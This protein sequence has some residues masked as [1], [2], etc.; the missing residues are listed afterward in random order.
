MLVGGIDKGFGYNTFFE[1]IAGR[2]NVRAVIVYGR[3]RKE[4]YRAAENA[5]IEEL[6][7]TV[8][9]DSAVR[10]AFGIAKRGDTVLLSPACASFDEFSDFEERGDAFAGLVKSYI[11]ENDLKCEKES[12]ASNAKE[13][14]CEDKEETCSKLKSDGVTQ[15]IKTSI[16]TDAISSFGDDSEIDGE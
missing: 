4:L 11:E 9:F 10:T 8:G 6:Y 12:F 14:R 7:L 3:S 5:C 1:N 13:G 16:V 15:G 2:G